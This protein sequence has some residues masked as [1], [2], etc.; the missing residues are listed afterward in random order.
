MVVD[1]CPPCPLQHKGPSLVS[2]V[3]RRVV[4]VLHDKPVETALK[5]LIPI[6]VLR[7]VV[8]AGGGVETAKLVAQGLKALGL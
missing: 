3:G 8:Y 2:R 5:K 7:A 1:P 4:S 6:L